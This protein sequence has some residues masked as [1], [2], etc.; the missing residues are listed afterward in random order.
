MRSV[1]HGLREEHVGRSV[2]IPRGNCLRAAVGLGFDPDFGVWGGHRD[3]KTYG[4]RT[5]MKRYW[6]RDK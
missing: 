1:V 2:G 6:R 5:Y 3:Q 4:Q